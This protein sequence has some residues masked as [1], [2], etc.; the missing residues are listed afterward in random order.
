M[1]DYNLSMRG[2]LAKKIDGKKSK[3]Y[4]N[5]RIC[6]ETGCETKLS[7]YNKEPYCWQHSDAVARVIPLDYRGPR[8]V[9]G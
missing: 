3:M 5:D 6:Q 4:P 2:E 1:V 7:V 9:R 8:K